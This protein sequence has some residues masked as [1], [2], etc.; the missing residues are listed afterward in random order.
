MNRRRFKDKTTKKV[1][2]TRINSS[3]LSPDTPTLTPPKS[4]PT[5]PLFRD[6]VLKEQSTRLLGD[7][8]MT[9]RVSMTWLCGVAFLIGAGIICFATLGTYTRRAT[10]AGE[11]IPAAGVIRVHTPQN[12][13]VL[14]KF[15]A[16]GQ[17]VRKGDTLF[18]LTSDR[19]SSVTREI[20]ADIGRQVDERKRSLE[21][22]AAR[23]R[24]I[25]VEE[26]RHLTQ[27][28]TM[29]KAETASLEKQIDQQVIRLRIAE[30]ARKRYEE[31]ANQDYVAREQLFQ[32]ES[33]LSEQQSRLQA[34]HREMLVSKR[35][36]ATTQR[37]IE[38]GRLRNANQHAQLQRN[39]SQATQEFTEVEA[40]RHVVITA[41]EAG[42]ATLVLAEVGQVVDA[43]KALVQ[44]VPHDSPL[45][46]RLYAP[47]RAIGFIRVGDPVQIRYQAFPF[48]KF[49][50]FEGV[51]ESVSQNTVS[52]SELAS[53]VVPNAILGEPAYAIKVTLH[54][55]QVQVYGKPLPLLSGMRLE[56]DI[57]QETRYLW[58]WMLEP[59]YSVTG[60]M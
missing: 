9:P 58:E 25:G 21:A 14:E 1:I 48:Q 44:I 27:R 30:D 60:K 42:R 10:V 43:S 50:Q 53:F 5:T 56:A 6:E 32:K 19:A 24:T 2:Y 52:S 51:V 13:V 54:Q 28:A 59:I 57:R 8:V 22:E 4:E 15:V 31:L 36:L 38:S 33:E 39:I 20:Q 55:Q 29:L 49:G 16:E 46:A 3:Q 40:R 12:G 45:Q 26:L 35:E 18:V 7:I 17:Q 23:N 11:L 47:S 37:E 41:P 34:L